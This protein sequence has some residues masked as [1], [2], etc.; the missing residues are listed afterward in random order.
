VPFTVSGGLNGNTGT[1]DVSLDG[2]QT[3]C[4][5]VALTAS[6]G[7]CTVT[8]TVAGT[9]AVSA[10]YNG[11]GSD[12]DDASATA[13]SSVVVAKQTPTLDVSAAPTAITGETVTATVSLATVGTVSPPTGSI[14]VSVDGSE[15]GCTL[16]ASGGTCD[17]SFVVTGN[18][19]VIT[20]SYSGDGNFNATSATPPTWSSA[21]LPAR[22]ASMASPRPAR[23]SVSLSAWPSR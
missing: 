16:G 23:W 4:D 6:A 1:V 9:F 13:S 22:S 21:A 12:V 5:D 10:L 3:G 19:R 14:T 15:T 18:P 7:S 2:G 20:A 11:D 17:V 8:P